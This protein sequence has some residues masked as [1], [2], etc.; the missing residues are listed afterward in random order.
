ME[1]LIR[2]ANQACSEGGRKAES[3]KGVMSTVL[4]HC[5]VVPEGGVKLQFILH[6][7]MS[8]MVEFQR[9]KRT[10]QT[11]SY[12]LREPQ[13]STGSSRKEGL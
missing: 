8:G 9:T 6:Q 5:L 13:A 11:L 12:W 1:K 10:P 3:W 2:V 7:N 4:A